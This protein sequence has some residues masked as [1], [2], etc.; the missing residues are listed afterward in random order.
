MRAWPV[1]KALVVALIVGSVA[2]ASTRQSSGK[3]G[4]PGEVVSGL[5]ELRQAVA[6]LFAT[7]E[8]SVPGRPRYGFRILE[9][10]DLP[11]NQMRPIFLREARRALV[12]NEPRAELS[13][14]QVVQGTAPGQVIGRVLWRP[15]AG[16]ALESLEVE[17][18]NGN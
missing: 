4:S 5:E 7:P 1:C 15:A 11:V 9:V 8:G 3:L 18:A 16:G 12:L 14:V 6:V 10:I 17:L 2:S 13:D